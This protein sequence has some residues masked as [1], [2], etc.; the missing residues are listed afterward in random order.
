MPAKEA[1]AADKPA[2]DKILRLDPN[3]LLKVVSENDI[4]MCGSGP[5][6]VMLHAVKALGATSGELVSYTNS[7]AVSGDFSNVVSYAG[8]IIS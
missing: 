1:E 2:L 4:S 6:A 7:G 5:T 3:G 8:I